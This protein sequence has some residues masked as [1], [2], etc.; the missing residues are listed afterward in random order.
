MGE[1]GLPGSNGSR[2][3]AE[4]A[5]RGDGVMRGPK[6]PPAHEAP[7]ARSPAT[8]RSYPGKVRRITTGGAITESA[9]D[10]DPFM[11][12][13]TAGPNGTVWADWN[14]GLSGTKRG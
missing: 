2:A 7:P 1:A 8:R 11:Q 10:P 12:Q 9:A 4:E 3:P 5:G 13:I 14:L 6:R